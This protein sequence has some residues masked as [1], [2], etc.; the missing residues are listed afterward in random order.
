MTNSDFRAHGYSIR[1]DQLALLKQIQQLARGSGELLRIMYET[2]GDSRTAIDIVTNINALDR[3]RDLT[4]IQARATGIPPEW[5]ER[6][7]VLGE[8][9]YAW[10]DDQPMPV[11]AARGQRRSVQRV[12]ADIERLKDIAAVSAAYRHTHAATQTS[13]PDDLDQTQLRRNMTALWIRAGRTADTTGMTADHREKLWATTAQ[14]WQRRVEHYLDSPDPE[15]LNTLWNRYNSPRIAADARKTLGRMRRDGEHGPDVALP[16]MPPTPADMLAQAEAATRHRSE[17]E[18][19]DN[20]IDIAVE[21]AIAQETVGTWTSESA[22]TA[23]VEAPMHD[24]DRTGGPD[25]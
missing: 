9:G 2:G 18:H 7:R 11:P 13:P 10:R 8:R 14:E 5:I 17:P 22:A 1:G 19:A 16:D 4:E 12:A 24:P 3:E 21:S 23:L 20:P 15:Q 25:P 6:V